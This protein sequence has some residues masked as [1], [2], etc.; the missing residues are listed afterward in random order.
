MTILN[1]SHTILNI[2]DEPNEKFK[3]IKIFIKIKK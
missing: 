1:T 2:I 3:K